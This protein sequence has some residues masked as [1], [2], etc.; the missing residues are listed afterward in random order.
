MDSKF[1]FSFL[2]KFDEYVCWIK[3][4]DFYK[5]K[6][7]INWFQSSDSYNR[8]HRR[9][10]HR[11]ENFINKKWFGSDDLC[12]SRESQSN[13]LFIIIIRMKGQRTTEVTMAYRKID[14]RNQWRDDS[15]SNFF[16]L[17]VSAAVWTKRFYHFHFTIKSDRNQRNSSYSKAEP[18]IFTMQNEDWPIGAVFFEIRWIIWKQI[19]G[20]YLVVK[21]WHI[22]CHWRLTSNW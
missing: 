5:R 22:F 12:L 3:L 13:T 21:H 11:P 20:Q 15:N 19:W 16:N 2:S 7:K 9:E 6:W 10:G 17:A 14:C 18:R 8:Y 1:R 4:F